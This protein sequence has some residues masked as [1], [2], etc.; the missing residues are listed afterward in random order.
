[1]LQRQVN[2][3]GGEAQEGPKVEGVTLTCIRVCGGGFI[4]AGALLITFPKLLQQA[5]SVDE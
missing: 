3:R 5:L 4:L 1:M 2:A